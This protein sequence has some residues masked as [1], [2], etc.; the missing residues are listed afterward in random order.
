[1]TE[2]TI[3]ALA[4]APGRS[5]VAMLRV[6]GPAAGAAVRRLGVEPLPAP[7]RATRRRIFHPSDG[8]PIDDAILLWFPGPASFTGEDVLELHL[9]GGPAV[10]A[11]ALDALGRIA[12]FRLAEPGEF[13]KRA[14]LNGKLDLTAAEGLADLVMAETEAQRKLALRQLE[15]ELGRLYESWRARL[16]GML[17][18]LEAAIDFPDEDLPPGLIERVRAGI[19]TL[20]REIAAHIGDAHRGERLRDGLSVALVGPPN[21]GKSSIFNYF[22][23][24]DAA[25]VSAVAG[26][27]RDVIEAHLDIGGY[28]VILADTA[29]LRLSADEIETEGVRRAMARARAADLWIGVLD[30]SAPGA[31]P[32]ELRALPAT[33][34]ILVANKTDLAP[35]PVETSVEATVEAQLAIDGVAA[36]AVSARTGVG[37]D[38]LRDRLGRMAAS[39]LAV[40]ASPVLTRARHREALEAAAAALD[41]AGRAELPELLA[42][43]LRLA[44]R[45][46]GRITGR[47]DVEDILDRIFAQF[48]IG[49]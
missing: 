25:I 33:R 15:G 49:K 42:E 6:S 5:G 13:T 23:K 41:R 31:V 26:T 7:R 27:T 2:A 16:V 47:V 19:S 11:R 14:F 17:A 22:V 45:S 8:T 36:L 18:A 43:D 4:T 46:V 44:T 24:R 1:M 3:F 10:L 38:A 21:S 39:A 20:G 32:A 48:C 28:P 37:M 34:A 29:G 12:G 35:A 9:H 30:A 40:G